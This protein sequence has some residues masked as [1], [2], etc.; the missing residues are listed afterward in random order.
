MKKWTLIVIIIIIGAWYSYES[1]QEHVA[2]KAALDF[3]L[4]C[5]PFIDLLP[6]NAH[7]LRP[8]PGGIITII[9][10]PANETIYTQG[11]MW[12]HD[13]CFDPAVCGNFGIMYSGLSE[14]C[15]DCPGVGTHTITVPCQGGGGE[16][17]CEKY[18]VEISAPFEIECGECATICAT[19]NN[20]I[21]PDYEWSTGEMTQCIEVCMAGEYSVTVMEQIDEDCMCMHAAVETIFIADSD[22]SCSLENIIV[23]AESFG[24]FDLEVT[25]TNSPFTY[26]WTGPN[27][28]SSTDEDPFAFEEGLYTVEVTDAEGCSV[29]CNGNVFLKSITSNP[30]CPI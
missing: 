11:T 24:Q 7:G 28:F 15:E 20:Y 30:Q 3:W 5:H 29:M 17:C 22:L 16:D 18:L 21:N 14:T 10:P 27:G 19:T 12:S 25:G 4:A 2:H 1:H 6:S 26:A 23:C 9:S 13:H 8:D